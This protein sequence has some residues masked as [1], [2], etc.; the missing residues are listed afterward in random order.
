MVSFYKPYI[1]KQV[2]SHERVDKEVFPYWRVSGHWGGHRGSH[3]VQLINT[4][5][6]INM[7]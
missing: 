1:Y 2:Y 6:L 5:Q 4:M 3:A 7:L